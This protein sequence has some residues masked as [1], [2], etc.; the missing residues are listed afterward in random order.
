MFSWNGDFRPMSSCLLIVGCVVGFAAAGVATL[1]FV[2]CC[3]SPTLP[4]DCNRGAARV[5]L[6]SAS[7]VLCQGLCPKTLPWDL[8]LVSL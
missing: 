1:V 5:V 3:P 4:L 7:A 8:P 6:R 2:L